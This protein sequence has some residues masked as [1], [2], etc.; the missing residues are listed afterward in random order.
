MRVIIPYNYVR[1]EQEIIVIFDTKI[2]L[3]IPVS[4]FKLNISV[5][6]VLSENA[7]PGTNLNVP[8]NDLEGCVTEA[9]DFNDNESIK[10]TCQFTTSG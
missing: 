7:T 3:E 5:N 10:L 8:T 1:K 6:K 2:P 9:L 4:D